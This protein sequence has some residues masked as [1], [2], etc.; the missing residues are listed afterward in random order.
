MYGGIPTLIDFQPIQMERTA[1]K[2]VWGNEISDNLLFIG[3][4]MKIREYPAGRPVTYLS[5]KCKY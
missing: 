1:I 3:K 4:Y 2:W 5:N